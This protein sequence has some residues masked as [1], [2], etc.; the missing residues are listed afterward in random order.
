MERFQILMILEK[1]NMEIE[2][3][4]FKIES[5]KKL[6]NHIVITTN[7]MDINYHLLIDIILVSGALS[8]VLIA[9]KMKNK[10]P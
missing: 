6:A 5:L 8:F 1:Q 7:K 4:D 3:E 2:E 9:R 10:N